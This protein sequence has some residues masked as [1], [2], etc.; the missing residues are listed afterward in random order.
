M[1]E[2]LLSFFGIIVGGIIALALA[3]A[4]LIGLPLWL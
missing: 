2:D 1:I 3:G 4:L